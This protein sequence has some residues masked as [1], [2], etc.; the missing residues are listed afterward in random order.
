MKRNLFAELNEGI[1]AL[2]DQREGKVTLREHPVEL[3]S[4]PEVT[5]VE[6]VQLR[7]RFPDTIDRLR[8]V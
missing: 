2:K 4:N 7:E 3:P 1:Q 6:L 5:S 8:A